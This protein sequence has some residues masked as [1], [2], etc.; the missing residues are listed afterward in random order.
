MASQLRNFSIERLSYRKDEAAACFGVSPS[1]FENWI[2]R[3]LMPPGIPIGGVRLWDADQL[4]AS[5]RKIL[6]SREI[7]TINLV[8]PEWGDDAA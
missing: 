4:R 7:K 5:W 3:Q 1:T 2:E 8:D 6:E